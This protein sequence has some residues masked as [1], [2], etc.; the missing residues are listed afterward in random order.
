MSSSTRQSLPARSRRRSASVIL[1]TVVV[2]A[3]TVSAGL[4]LGARPA[5]AAVSTIT[6]PDIS[7]YNHTGPMDLYAMKASGQSFVFV[8]ATEG[9]GPSAYVNPYF[10]NDFANAAGAGLYRGAYDFARPQL[11]LSSAA[12]QANFFADKVGSIHSAMDLPPVVDLEVS[13]GLS[14]ADLTLWL[15]VWLNTA[16]AR[17]GR[18]P[19]IYSGPGF[20]ASAMAG[21]TQF[22]SYP[23]WEAEWTTAGAPDPMG[24]WRK[25]T[26]WQFTNNAALTG[27]TGR[28]DNN[29]FQGSAADL[30]ALAAERPST[31]PYPDGTFIVSSSTG[32]VYRTAGGAPLYVSTWAAFPPGQPIRMVDQAIIDS[33]PPVPA[34]GTVLVGSQ[35]GEWYIVAGGAPL[36][37]STF[38]PIPAGTN[39][40]VVDQNAI[41][42]AGA[43]GVYSHLRQRPLDGTYVVGAQRGEWY[44]IA[45]GAPIYV[46][47]FAAVPPGSR[48]TIV[49]QSAID[50][51]GAGG[52]WNHLRAQ[53]ADGTVLIGQPRGELYVVAGGA[54]IYSSTYDV[55]PA[56]ATLTWTD[57]NAID[58]AGA[59]GLWNHLRAQPAD[60]TVLVAQQRGAVYI[61]AGGAPLYTGTTQPITPNRVWVTVDAGSID[62]AGATRYWSHLQARPADGTVLIGAQ[63]GEWYIVAG[64]APL[65]TSTTSPVPAGRLAVR[66]DQGALDGA[67]AGP[68]TGHLD[69]KPANGTV[70]IGQQRGEWYIVAGGAPIYTSTFAPV[71]AHAR[72]IVVDINAMD[73]AG[74]GSPWNHMTMHPALSTLIRAVPTQTLYRINSLGQPTVYV[75]P[76]NATTDAA[77]ITLQ[78]KAAIDNAG[79]P[80][81]W[82]HLVR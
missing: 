63:R 7:N 42:A 5:E 30:V 74:S 19:M 73:N 9:A 14:P 62:N 23:L 48:G 12:D 17:F 37:T 47:T 24:G 71:P 57:Q 49:D 70:L 4:S 53:P 46:T 33:L 2:L 26:F 41:D 29:R 10:K 68:W 28:V 18:V 27:I 38:A 11:P 75:A 15:Q 13:G 51:A 72:P 55:V 39:A 67:G 31:S 60:G 3:A 45:G 82:N 34:D 25:A 52:L 76:A 44:V 56:N 35:R 64:G 21:T 22:A 81:P 32:A 1:T 40:V 50:G 66:V 16:H 78:D 65:Y 59:G 36:Y 69:A 54:P 20:W 80:R 6:G 79:G 43:P 61:V 77:L 8:K 58:G